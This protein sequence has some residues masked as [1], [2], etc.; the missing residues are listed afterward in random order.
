MSDPCPVIFLQNAWFP[1]NT[2]ESAMRQ[3]ATDV[4]FR[5]KVLSGTMTGKRLLKA[6]GEE[7]F[8]RVWWDNATPIPSIGTHRGFEHPD[9]AHMLRVI[10]DQRP[11]VIGLLG[12]QAQLGFLT[13]VRKDIGLEMV[14]D[15][16]LTMLDTLT[17]RRYGIVRGRHPNAMGIK[18]TEINE[19]AKRVIAAHQKFS[20][21]N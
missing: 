21:G 6:F 8:E 14:R 15:S 3:Y 9:P 10:E 1:P 16:H 19:F 4:R 11:R 12:N 5:R 17:F 20:N 2:R 18:Q 13:M 7:W